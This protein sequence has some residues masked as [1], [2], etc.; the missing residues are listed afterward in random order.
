MKPRLSIIIPLHNETRRLPLALDR[1]RAVNWPY[2]IEI[3]GV[4]NGSTDDTARLSLAYANLYDNYYH[5]QVDARGK[6]AAV[7]AGML[8]ARGDYCYMADVDFATPPNWVTYFLYHAVKERADLVIGVRTAR[9]GYRSLVGR[10]FHLATRALIPGII[11]SQ[12]GF[13]LFSARAAADLFSRSRIEGM[14]F[15]V[16][17]LYLARR[18]GYRIEQMAVPWTHDPDS[19]VNVLSDGWQMFQDVLRIPGLHPQGMAD[20]K[21][22]A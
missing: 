4:E 6:G 1:I 8:A 14:A 5:W 22:P 7:R 12:C 21:A 11:D 20:Q 17:V 13:K 19:R 18:L 2:P 16:E 3:I 15:D 9:E 10:M